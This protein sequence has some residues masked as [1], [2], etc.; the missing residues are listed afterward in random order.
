MGIL[1]ELTMF[2][3]EENEDSSA[4]DEG[5]GI[6]GLTRK[7]GS[8]RRG[9]PQNSSHSVSAEKRFALATAS[10]KATASRL[11]RDAQHEDSC[12]EYVHTVILPISKSAN[13]S[14]VCRAT[15]IPRL[16]CVGSIAST[17]SRACKPNV[18]TVEGLALN[19]S[20]SCA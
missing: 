13:I 16:A 17:G 9:T 15:P 11:R 3:D 6:Y 7:T 18:V 1:E 8:D 2:L 14:F 5:P 20:C 10:P 19:K 12:V 4:Q